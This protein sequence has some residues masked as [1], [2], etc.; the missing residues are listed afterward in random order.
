METQTKQTTQE[1]MA[2]IRRGQ[3]VYGIPKLPHKIDAMYENQCRGNLMAY[4]L[5]ADPVKGDPIHEKLGKLLSFYV[6]LGRAQDFEKVARNHQHDMQA[7]QMN[8]QTY[9]HIRDTS[10]KA[11]KWEFHLKYQKDPFL[12]RDIEER[13][14]YMFGD[15]EKKWLDYPN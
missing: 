15:P 9:N 4:Y 3:K 12:R 11:L 7:R 5:D 8:E 13:H 10:L 2:Q 1:R 6:T 14:E